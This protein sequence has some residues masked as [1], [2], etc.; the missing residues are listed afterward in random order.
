MCINREMVLQ[1]ASSGE[2]GALQQATGS[3]VTTGG[4]EMTQQDEILPY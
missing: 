2:S 3:A 4:G 1:S